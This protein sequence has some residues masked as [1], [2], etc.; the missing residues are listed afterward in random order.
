MSVFAIGDTHLS[1]GTDKP[2]DVFRGWT[3]YTEKLREN[4]IKSVGENDTVVIPGDISW[5]M[6]LEESEKD[7]E[8]LHSL[9][10]EKII[11][12]GNHDY[13]WSTKGKM[14]AFLSSKGF[15]SIK[16]LHNNAYKVGDFAICGTRGWFFD[17]DE[18][19]S[20]KIILR[21]AMRLKTSLECA[22]K[23][24]G[25][26]LVFLH[27][28]PL[29][30]TQKCDEIYNILLQYPVK[31]CFYGHIHADMMEKYSCFFKDGIE[32]KLVSADYLKFSP[33]LIEEF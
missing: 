2:M 15:H 28:P 18:P 29:S 19:H 11:L 27:Y 24:G 25:E 14:D 20:E 9:P 13:W 1:F 26:L 17:D 4:W 6:R 3:S 12:K 16:I 7:F 5:A 23:L 32:F 30:S 21:E 22:M 31:R 8:F 10:G 33:L